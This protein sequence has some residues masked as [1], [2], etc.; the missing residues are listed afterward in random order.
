[1]TSPADVHG[2]AEQVYREVAPRL[3]VHVLCCEFALLVCGVAAALDLARPIIGC[4]RR[5]APKSRLSKM[6]RRRLL[7][8]H[9]G[10]LISPRK[11][12]FYPLDISLCDLPTLIIQY[13]L[14]THFPFRIEVR[15]NGE[16]G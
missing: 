13:K 14:E 7:G 16:S 3:G 8:I 6:H 9:N 5:E 2:I 1:M 10:L 4:R 15:V 11:I 12:A